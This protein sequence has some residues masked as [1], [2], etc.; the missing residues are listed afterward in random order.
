[1]GLKKLDIPVEMLTKELLDTATKMTESWKD[2]VAFYTIRLA[3]APVVE[4]LILLDRTMFLYEQGKSI[5][6]DGEGLLLLVQNKFCS[7]LIMNFPTFHWT[8]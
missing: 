6:P 1:M 8:D 4:T 5:K 3:L 2:V 7:L